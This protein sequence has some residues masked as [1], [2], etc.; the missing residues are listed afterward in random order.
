MLSHVCVSPCLQ[1]LGQNTT[2]TYTVSLSPQYL[3]N[4]DGTGI[5]E[6]VTSDVS[7]TIA[8][9]AGAI[10]VY[11]PTITVNIPETMPV[12]LQPICKNLRE[13]VV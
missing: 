4:P 9:S 5:L 12:N 13:S 11:R 7:A 8:V 2:Y 1:F 6:M 10:A 3:V